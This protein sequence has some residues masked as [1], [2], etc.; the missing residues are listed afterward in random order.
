LLNEAVQLRAAMDGFLAR[1]MTSLGAPVTGQS[2][3][4]RQPSVR[5]QQP[6]APSS[7]HWKPQFLEW[8]TLLA[9]TCRSQRHPLSLMIIAIGDS[10]PP[11]SD[12][13]D[14]VSQ[15]LDEACGIELPANA[16]I[17]RNTSWQKT[18][19]LPSCDRQ[20]AVQ[21]AYSLMRNIEIALKRSAAAGCPIQGVI[22]AG[23]AAVTLP[24]KNFQPMDLVLTAE[25]CLT[26]A[27]ASETNVV[28]SLEIY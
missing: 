28:K 22:S 19:V 2:H 8:L 23:V 20:E 5:G 6:A 14:L 12:G 11:T 7:T 21:V 3:L 25:R 16:L 13:E 1:P 17:E 9:G 27:Q 18:I 15:W 4:Q 24:S 26:A 10:T